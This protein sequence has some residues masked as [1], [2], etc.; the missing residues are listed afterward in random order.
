MSAL[1]IS[2]GFDFKYLN[3]GYYDYINNYYCIEEYPN[4]IDNSYNKIEFNNYLDKIMKV[5]NMK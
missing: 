1:Y 3:I 4:K 2:S 5:Y